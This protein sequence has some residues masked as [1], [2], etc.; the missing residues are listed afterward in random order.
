VNQ[1]AW[2]DSLAGIIQCG[3]CN[4]G[5]FIQDFTKDYPPGVAVVK[6]EEFLESFT[7]GPNEYVGKFPIRKDL[8]VI[9]KGCIIPM[10]EEEIFRLSARQ[11]MTVLGP[12]DPKKLKLGFKI[13]ERPWGLPKGAVWVIEEELA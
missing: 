9:P 7:I 10:K 3:N 1:W 8:S 4:H 11:E 13:Y 12:D 2:A 6:D 5:G